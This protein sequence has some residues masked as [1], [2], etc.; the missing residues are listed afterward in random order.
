MGKNKL[1]RK[2]LGQNFR[3]LRKRQGYTL[4][5]L[6]NIFGVSAPTICRMENG[7]Q[8]TTKNLEFFCKILG[9]TLEELYSR[10]YKNITPA[11]FQANINKHINILPLSAASYKRINAKAEK[12]H[13][14]SYLA[15]M[16]VE[17]GF[18]NEFREV[19][20]VQEYIQSK[21]NIPLVSSTITNA[22]KR[23]T[24]IIHKQSDRRGHLKYKYNN[25]QKSPRKKK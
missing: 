21:Y 3:E 1:D 12:S 16:A 10:R 11:T 14:P 23:N 9:I 25:P 13:G 15:K 22:L 17:D 5:D 24:A 7:S 8:S 6:Q 19:R 18:L 20:E 4:Q 2:Q